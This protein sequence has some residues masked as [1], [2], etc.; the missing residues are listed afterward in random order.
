MEASEEG[1]CGSMLRSLIVRDEP[2]SVAEV[3]AAVDTIAV[4]HGLSPEGAFD[5]KLATT[6]A[7]ANALR[8]SPEDALGIDV[9]LESDQEVVQVEVVG[10]GRFRLAEG[11]DPE[12]GRGLP[13]MIALADE[14]EFAASGNG[15]RVRIRMR[16]AR[17]DQIGPAV[18]EATAAD[19]GVGVPACDRRDLHDVAGVRRMDELV[20]ADVDPDVAEAVEEHEVAGL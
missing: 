16:V 10:R 2:S 12:R 14:V 13:L 15:T 3:R 5:L 17:E 4:E 18:L 7:V 9:T 1:E 8:N 19:P 6:E 11:L 20:A